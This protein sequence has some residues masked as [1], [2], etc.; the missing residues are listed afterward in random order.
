MDSWFQLIE[1]F[2]HVQTFQLVESKNERI[3]FRMV[4]QS[5]R[6]R[7]TNQRFALRKMRRYS[8]FLR[9]IILEKNKNAMLSILFLA[10]KFH[11]VTITFKQDNVL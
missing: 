1:K 8:K 4:G 2:E 6:L 5:Q 10:P 9:N 3:V 11:L 7:S